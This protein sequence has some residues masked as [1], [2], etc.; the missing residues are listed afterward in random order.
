MPERNWL[1]Q[2]VK[3][4][5]SEVLEGHLAPIQSDLVER[6]LREVEP[7]LGASPGGNSASLLKAVSSIQSGTTQREILRTL[8]D[9]AAHYTGRV[10]L[11]VIKTGTA[12]GWQAR[13]FAHSE[14][15]KDF[16]LGI[17]SGL[18]AQVLQSRTAA[19]GPADQMDSDFITRFQPPAD[20]TVLLLP[21][22]LKE[23]VAALVYADAGSDPGGRMDA[24]A[25]ELLVVATGAWLEVVALRKQNAKESSS[26]TAGH[27]SA[28]HENTPH[29]K[30]TPAPAP[31][32]SDPFAAHAPAH[33]HI[34]EPSVEAPVA[35]AQETAAVASMAAQTESAPLP[36]TPGAA[37]TAAAVAPDA[38]AGLSP[39]DAE[40]HCKAQ[41]FA[42]LL[43]DEIKLYNQAKV[44]EGR[45]NRDLYDRLK[46]DID[47]SFATYQK[48]YGN[49]VAA[50]AG[51][52]NGELVRSLAEDDISLLGANFQR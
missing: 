51:Y 48:R 40:I 29:E 33:L 2:V 15:I 49:T 4:A 45:K 30:T 39:E 52:F 32:L 50:S 20:G 21:L 18:A 34:P 38:L 16:G 31:S 6:V 19:S 46:E 1:E 11:F 5:V 35:V 8:L 7:R 47:K 36:D 10:A 17:G 41:R 22:V 12:T 44:S 3:S 27:E 28:G 43:V 37:A 42:R 25:F 26:E 13:G 9:G 24:A 23:K 14:E